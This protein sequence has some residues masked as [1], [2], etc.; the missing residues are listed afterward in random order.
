MGIGGKMDEGVGESD[1]EEERMIVAREEERG[2]WGG[3][4]GEE[5]DRER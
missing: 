3:G 4:K 5:R 1:G 2:K